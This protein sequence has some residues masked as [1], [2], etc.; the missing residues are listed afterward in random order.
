MAHIGEDRRIHIVEPAPTVPDTP[1]PLTA[2]TQGRPTG[3]A[4][5]DAPTTTPEPVP[6]E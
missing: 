2:P 6:A 3:A 4:T 1:E 5:H